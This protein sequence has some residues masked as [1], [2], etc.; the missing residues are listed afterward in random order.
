MDVLHHHLEPV[1][2]SRFRN[3]NLIRKLLSK[4]LNDDAVGGGEKGEYHFD[5]VLLIRIEFVPVFQI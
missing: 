1:E 2:A 5:E 3:L 4:V